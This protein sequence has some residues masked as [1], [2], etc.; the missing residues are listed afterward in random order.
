M[1][2]KYYRNNMSAFSVAEYWRL[3][4]FNPLLFP[5]AIV[6]FKIFR[7]RG[8]VNMA[9]A[10]IAEIERVPAEE[11]APAAKSGLRNI[12]AEC[13]GEGL[14]VDCY[15]TTDIVSAN[16]SVGVL[17]LSPDKRISHQLIF[18]MPKETN[19]PTSC[20]FTCYSSCTDGT[21]VIT[22]GGPQQLNSA[23]VFD[24]EYRTG[25]PV[26]EIVERHRQRIATRRDVRSCSQE[27]MAKDIA[28]IN[29]LVLEHM[30]AEGKAVEMSIFEVTELKR[31]LGY[32]RS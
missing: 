2:K 28:R 12:L 19:V 7:M 14:G 18:G 6:L 22:T 8:D 31:K 15:Y 27:E 23:P 1:E 4:R 32:F 29:N 24:V 9:Q 16:I 25:K 20:F 30:I 5:L 21:Y 26:R 17:L 3:C 11:V 10:L 13:E